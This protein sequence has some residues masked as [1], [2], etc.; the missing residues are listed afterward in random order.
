MRAYLALAISFAWRGEDGDSARLEHLALFEKKMEALR[1][2]LA[3]EN[4]DAKTAQG[5]IKTAASPKYAPSGGCDSGPPCVCCDNG[6][7]RACCDSG[8]PRVSVC[9][10]QRQQRV[11]RSGRFNVKRSQAAELVARGL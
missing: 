3:I 1:R 2:R 8:Q 11:A 6:Q 5:N 9:L 10:R 7:P 4:D